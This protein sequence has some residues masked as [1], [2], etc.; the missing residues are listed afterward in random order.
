MRPVSKGDTKLVFR[1]H[2]DLGDATL[3]GIMVE[4]L[5]KNLLKEYYRWVKE[6]GQNETIME[7]LNEWVAEEADFQT[8]VS[9][10]KHSFTQKYKDSKW[11]WQDRKN[12]KL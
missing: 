5:P 8:Q 12:N 9:E 11:S 2:A 1:L 10:L 3:Y 7:T 6:Q 4:K